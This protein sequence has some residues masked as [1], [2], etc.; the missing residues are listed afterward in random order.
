MQYAQKRGRLLIL[1]LFLGLMWPLSQATAQGDAGI[2]R[3]KCS[4]WNNIMNEVDRILYIGGLRDGLIFSEMVIQGV[5]LPFLSNDE[6]VR[7]VDW[8]C[9]DPANLRIPIPIVLKVAGMRTLGMS[10]QAIDDE[11]SDQRAMFEALGG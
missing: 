7:A 9:N 8:V 1:G 4:G 5:Q 11:L 6:A 10:Q 3:V 2:F